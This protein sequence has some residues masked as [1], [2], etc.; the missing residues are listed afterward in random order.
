MGWQQGLQSILIL[1]MA[2]NTRCMK[3]KFLAIF[4]K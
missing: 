3:N 2:E 1:Y 4:P